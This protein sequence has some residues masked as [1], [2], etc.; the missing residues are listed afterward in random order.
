MPT[1]QRGHATARTA[2]DGLPLVLGFVGAWRQA[3]EAAEGRVLGTPRTTGSGGRRRRGSNGLS[4][5]SPPRRR[6]CWGLARRRVDGGDSWLCSPRRVGGMCGDVARF[7]LLW[8]Y[9]ARAGGQE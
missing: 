7:P 1:P 4:P 2:P 5:P 3:I 9:S 8:W 6:G